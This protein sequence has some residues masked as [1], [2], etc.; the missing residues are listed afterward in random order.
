MQKK[1][2]SLPPADYIYTYITT[3]SLSGGKKYML[4]MEN[5]NTKKQ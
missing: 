3:T 4:M 5:A 2:E 1:K